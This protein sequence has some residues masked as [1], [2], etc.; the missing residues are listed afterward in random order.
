M[1][2]HIDDDDEVLE[3]LEDDDLLECIG[4][5]IPSGWAFA[6]L[7]DADCGSVDLGGWV[8]DGD[9]AHIVVH[10]P[11]ALLGRISNPCTRRQY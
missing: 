5:H 1:T 7:D 2:W 11:A 10:R 6:W 9:I 4:E 8:E 3:A